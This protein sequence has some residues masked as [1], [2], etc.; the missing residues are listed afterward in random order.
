[1]VNASLFGGAVIMKMTVNQVRMKKAVWRHICAHV[2]Q[3]NSHVPLAAAYWYGSLLL[4]L[5]MIKP[6]C[7]I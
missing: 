5:N 6:Y 1:M 2:D 7:C 4:H 3:M